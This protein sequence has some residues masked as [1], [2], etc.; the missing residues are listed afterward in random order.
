MA[1]QTATQVAEAELSMYPALQ[2]QPLLW[3]DSFG[4]VHHAPTSLGSDVAVVICPGVGRDSSTGYRPAR[5]LADQLALAGY[6]AIRFSYPGTGDS[7]DPAEE[8]CWPAWTESVQSAVDTAL[9]ISGVR[10]VVLIGVRLG[11]ALA[12]LAASLRKEVV[13]LVLLEPVVRGSSFVTQL[14]MEEKISAGAAAVDHDGVRI[15]GLHLT[16]EALSGIASLDLRSVKLR[17]DC[18]V[19]VLSETASGA[20]R[21]CEESWSSQGADVA[22]ENPD[23]MSAFFRPTHLADEEFPDMQS[24]TD[25]LQIRFPVTGRTASLLP[26]RGEVAVEG[27]GWTETPHFMGIDRHLFGIMCEP[28]APD[29]SD[30]VVVI[31]NSGGDPHDGF[32]RFAVD[33]A[34]HLAAHGVASLRMDFAGLGDSVN[35]ADDRDGVTHPFTVDRGPDFAAAVDFLWARGFRNIA[36]QGLCSGAYHALQAAVFEPRVSTL[37]CVSLPWFSLRFEKPGPASFATRACADLEARGVRSLLLY[38]EEDAGLKPL[39]QHFG[40]RGRELS[41]RQG[42]DVV[43]RPDIDHD[44]TRPQMRRIATEQMMTLLRQETDCAE[45][46]APRA[47]HL[48]KEGVL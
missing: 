43:I 39:E 33:F 3:G 35:A 23:A 36:V 32:A 8:N 34:R 4:W 25:W 16:A 21:G 10:R 30:T 26:S 18:K 1:M 40:P 48:I 19:L 20:L 46:S 45:A 2:R 22:H 15:H 11:A 28:E 38:A 27:P 14:R 5:F 42:F 41:A 37:L 9:T 47:R 31:G 17:P 12:A 44:L 24:L 29:R 7:R 6:T 13:G